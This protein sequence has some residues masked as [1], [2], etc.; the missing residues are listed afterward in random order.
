MVATFEQLRTKKLKSFDK[1]RAKP[2][3]P[4]Y[5]TIA[6]PT[7]PEERGIWDYDKQL[8]QLFEQDLES[9]LPMDVRYKFGRI[10]GMTEKPDETKDRMK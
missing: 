1:L 3:P 10:V 5:G 9:L 2:E 7:T 6:I 8:E 4:N